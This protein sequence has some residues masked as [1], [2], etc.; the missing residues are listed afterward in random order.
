MGNHVN[1]WEYMQCGRVSC[2]AGDTEGGVCPVVEA[3]YYHGVNEGVNGGRFC[4]AV[5][6]TLCHGQVQ[7]TFAQ[8][9]MDCMK[10]E[11]YGQLYRQFGYDLILNPEQLK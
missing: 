10:C 1:C 11:F 4:W 3:E 6:G 5:A 2:E 7:G 9:A 8:K